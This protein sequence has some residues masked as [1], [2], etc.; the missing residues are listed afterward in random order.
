MGSNRMLSAVLVAALAMLALCVSTGMAA[1]LLAG[2]AKVDIT[3]KEPAYLAGYGINRLSEAVKEPLS[4]RA[5]VLKSGE[6]TLTVVGV[7]SLGVPGRI[8]KDIRAMIKSVPADSV[9]IA[10]THDHSAPDIFG[11]WGPNPTT[12]G[13]NPAYLAFLKQSIVTAVDQAA[14]AVKPAKLKLGSVQTKGINVNHR[15]PE[16][17]DHEL[18]AMQFVGDDGKVIATLANFPC[19]AEIMQSKLL[20]GDFPY[21]FYTKIEKDQGGVAIFINGALGGMITADIPGGIYS[22]EGK[23]NS[24]WAQR[25]GEAVADAT[26]QALA[27]ASPIENPELDYKFVD[28][29]LPFRNE[30]AQAAMK[31]GAM[32]NALADNKLVT[33]VAAV[34]L[35]PAQIVTIPGE[36]LPNLGFHLKRVM[37]GNPKFLFGLT[38][39][40]LGYILSGDDWGMEIYSYE[41][42]TGAGPNTGPLLMATLLPLIDEVKPAAEEAP[43]AGTTAPGAPTTAA[44]FFAGLPA[45]FKAD[46]A[47]GLNAAYYFKLTGDGA[48]D[49]T[50][51]IADQKCSVKQG[52]PDKAD[53]TITAAASDW[54][55]IV[56]GEADAASLYM[57]GKL[58]VDGDLML[59]QRFTDLFGV[60]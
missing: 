36:A 13:V 19:H 58:S 4:A 12:S 20:S 49:W 6:K 9:M 60:R 8:Q 14:A 44:Q 42:R 18:A 50:V 45:H 21:Y 43:A 3:P 59:A 53:V 35:G 33:K 24:I 25:I 31:S 7:D 16:I 10:A 41:S 46:R 32:P 28:L 47:A 37:T 23:D 26:E 39:D 56:S 54:M 34:A 1:Q 51:S 2:A 27:N 15:I 11:M 5:L 17:V 30:R 48:G 22:L 57:A 52:A 29:E 38:M 55:G 40:E